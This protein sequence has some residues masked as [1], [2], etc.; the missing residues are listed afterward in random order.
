PTSPRT[1]TPARAT[2]KRCATNSR[3]RADGRHGLAWLLHFACDMPSP[4]PSEPAISTPSRKRRDTRVAAVL[5]PTI[6]ASSLLLAGVAL[7]V[8]PTAACFCDCGGAFN[9]FDV[10]TA[11]APIAT[12]SVTGDA[13]GETSCVDPDQSPGGTGCYQFTVK[14]TQVGTCHIE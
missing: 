1:P 12:L 10:T 2:S 5:A 4:E 11:S 3:S 8:V 13:C 6:L 14:L 9:F 7:S